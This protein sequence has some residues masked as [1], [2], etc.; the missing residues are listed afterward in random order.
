MLDSSGPRLSVFGCI[1]YFMMIIIGLLQQ[2][3]L[4]DFRSLLHSASSIKYYC[5]TIYFPLGIA[6]MRL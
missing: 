1:M 2:V 5:S 4:T 3:I 6:S